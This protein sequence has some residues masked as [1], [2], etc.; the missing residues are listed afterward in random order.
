MYQIYF[1]LLILCGPQGHAL[2]L[3][4]TIDSSPGS[5]E[6]TM[7]SYSSYIGGI[8]TPLYGTGAV[9]WA[10]ASRVR[11]WPHTQLG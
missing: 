7:R 5:G 2:Y 9:S 11:F 8:L 1:T 6:Y 4:T 10:R 3:N